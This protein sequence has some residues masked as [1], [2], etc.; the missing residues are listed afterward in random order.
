[1]TINE[2][3]GLEEEGLPRPPHPKVTTFFP[4]NQIFGMTMCQYEH[5]DLSG[6]NTLIFNNLQ[7]ILDIL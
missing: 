3:A 6:H 7:L 4:Y 2:L 1:M 5:D